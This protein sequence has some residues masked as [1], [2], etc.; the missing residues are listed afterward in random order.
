MKTLFSSPTTRVLALEV[1]SSR[2][3]V[4]EIDVTATGIQ[5][6]NT[7]VI[8]YLPDA[9]DLAQ[10]QLC[11]TLET[12]G[13]TTKRA[14]MSITGTDVG[15]TSLQ[16]PPLSKNERDIIV[17][18]E[19]QEVIG[20]SFADYE[21]EYRVLRRLEEAEVSQDQ[22]LL[23][24][25]PRQKLIAAHE[26][27]QRCGLQLE[28]ITPLPLALAALARAS[29]PLGEIGLVSLVDAGA[30]LVIV[31]DGQFRFHRE[32]RAGM[33]A[34]A[35][36]ARNVELLGAE[37]RS[38]LLY[39]RQQFRGERV[40][41]LL[42]C[43]D[44][45][46][47]ATCTSITTITQLMA[48]PCDLTSLAN[49]SQLNGERGGFQDIVPAVTVPLGLALG[50]AEEMNLLPTFVRERSGSWG[51]VVAATLGIAI[52]CGLL[53]GHNSVS[54]QV[55]QVEAAIQAKEQ[56]QARLQPPVEKARTT[57]RHRAYDHAR[58][59]FLEHAPRHAMF[60]PQLLHEINRLVPRSIVLQSVD[61]SRTQASRRINM[62]GEVVGSELTSALAILED[63]YKEA[64][65]SPFLVEPTISMNHQPNTAGA[66][67]GHNNAVSFHIGAS[68]AIKDLLVVQS[69]S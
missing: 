67:Q 26:F 40:E 2:I 21:Y 20:S 57:Q 32:I 43:G 46:L 45:N 63:F 39:F 27:I 28:R 13:I 6:T 64:Q 68:L 38:S 16:L 10:A 62:T 50:S 8:D 37:I 5:I 12:K 55:A 65:R 58:V 33:K 48:E 4:L 9:E 23:S 15:I 60:F 44:G 34:S 3:N 54:A 30:H 51:L 36:G 59:L 35:D 69:G 25:A 1:S 31:K 56:E 7:A 53:W 24:Y 52:L 47:D 49:L 41:K 17:Q 22:I 11:E 66:E 29:H 19:A 42:V 18:R 61:I 14:V